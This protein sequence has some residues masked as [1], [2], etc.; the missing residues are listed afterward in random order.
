[1]TETSLTSNL[2]LSREKGGKYTRQTDLTSNLSLS[3]KP[4]Q[5]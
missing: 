5:W 4:T 3:P 1:M 2:S